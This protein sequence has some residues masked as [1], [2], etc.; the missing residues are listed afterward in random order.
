MLVTVGVL[1]AVLDDV[2][3]VVLGFTPS[4]A[5]IVAV[6]SVVGFVVVVLMVVVVTEVDVSVPVVLVD[7]VPSMARLNVT[8][9]PARWLLANGWFNVTK[10][11]T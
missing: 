9:V 1:V 6:I 3:I 4:V 2:A 7:E 8:D 11:A 10:P 5:E